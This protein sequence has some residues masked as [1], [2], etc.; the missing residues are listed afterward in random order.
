MFRIRHC[1][2]TSFLVAAS[3][4]QTAFAE[5]L[6]PVGDLTIVLRETPIPHEDE[7]A[8][9]RLGK[10]ISRYYKEAL[11]G[12]ENWE[13]VESL[14]L[15]GVLTLESGDF[16]MS[17]L[18]KKPNLIKMSVRHPEKGQIMQLGF[19]GETAWQLMPSAAAPDVMSG[20]AARRFIHSAHF[21]NHLIYPFAQGKTISYIDT[22]PVEGAICHQIRVTLDSGYQVDYFLDIRTYLEIKV[23]NTDLRNEMTNSIIYA[24]YI[25]ESGIPIAR[26]VES[27]EEGEW[28]SSLRLEDIRVNSGVMPWMFHMPE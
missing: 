15:S 26:K 7:L 16:D 22:V 3:A 13:K 20:Q 24:D 2:Y 9:S 19:D 6:E 4:F 12:A 18:Q 21:G 17:A 11:G 27:Y 1:I 28:V 23:E 25:V 14:N 5:T 10:I 8:D